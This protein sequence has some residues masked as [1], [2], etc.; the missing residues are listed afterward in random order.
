M[1]LERDEY[2]DIYIKDEFAPCMGL[3]SIALSNSF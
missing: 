1:G 2:L 3:E